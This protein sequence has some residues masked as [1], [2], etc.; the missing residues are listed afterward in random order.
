MTKG[1]RQR[2]Q[3]TPRRGSRLA[4]LMWAGGLVLVFAVFAVFAI[5]RNEAQA[6]ER[7]PK[8]LWSGDFDGGDLRQY[9]TVQEAAEDRITIVTSPRRE[10]RF[11]ARL[12]ANDADLLGGENPRAQ[13]MTAPMHMPGDDRYIGWST[14]FP[15]AFPAIEGPGA[16]FVFFEFH[17][18]PYNGSPSLGF[19]VGADGRI[20]L[21]RGRRYGYDRVWSTPLARSRWIDFAVHVKWSKDENEG[22]VELWVDGERQT[23]EENGEQRL[24]TQTI[25]DDQDGGLK[26]IPTNYRRHGSVPG[27]VTLFHDEVK[28]GPTY[29]S[30]AP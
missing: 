30:V 27:D 7:S 10:G 6:P 13:L 15:D 18:P 28:V 22:F 8:L 3:E 29:E 16:F 4:S 23:F 17:G 12:T 24:Y 26:T 11:A 20:E 1:Q 5:L 19:G 9:P 21:R 2:V 25:E 14:Y